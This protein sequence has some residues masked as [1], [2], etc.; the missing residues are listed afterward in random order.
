MIDLCSMFLVC[1]EI[2]EEV[3]EE[4]VGGDIEEVYFFIYLI[5]IWKISNI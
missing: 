4:D 5:V 2:E 1:I 3:D